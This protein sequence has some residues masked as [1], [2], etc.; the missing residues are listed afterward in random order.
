[1]DLLREG[2]IMQDHGIEFAVAMILWLWK[3]HF[4]VSHKYLRIYEGNVQQSL[5]T[6]MVLIKRYN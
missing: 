5:V 4:G 2:N 6:F 3:T 1:M